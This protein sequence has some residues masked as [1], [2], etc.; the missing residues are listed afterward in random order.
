MVV[1]IAKVVLVVPAGTTTEEGTVTCEVDEERLTVQP[2]LGAGWLIVTVPVQEPPAV[3]GFGE[4]LT[5]L[6]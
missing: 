2:P 4:A 6:K 5:L 1:A 3:T